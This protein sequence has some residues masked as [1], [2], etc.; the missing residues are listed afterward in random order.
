MTPDIASKPSFSSDDAGKFYF[1][2]GAAGGYGILVKQEYNY[3]YVLGVLNSKITEF[4]IKNISTQMRGGYYSFES[5]YIKSIPIKIPTTSKEK[6]SA[7]RITELVLEATTLN[8]RLNLLRGKTT[9]EKDSL[10]KE[11]EKIENQ[12]DQEVYKIYGLTK[13]EIQIVETSPK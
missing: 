9:D 1:L 4:I 6:I 3:K 5:R 13:E 12:I 8:Q 10:E 2:G 7:D 11:I